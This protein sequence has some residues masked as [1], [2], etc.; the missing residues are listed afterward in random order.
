MN[1]SGMDIIRDMVSIRR[2]VQAGDCQSLSNMLQMTIRRKFT[3]PLDRLYAILGIIRPEERRAV[4]VDYSKT[5]EQLY[6]DIAGLCI[7]T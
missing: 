2:S 1:A 4:T 3:N 7:D 6:I 5:V